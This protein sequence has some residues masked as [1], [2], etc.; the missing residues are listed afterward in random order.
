M[1][2]RLL[3]ELQPRRM[4]MTIDVVNDDGTITVSSG[5]G[6]TIR[7]LGTGSVGDKVYVQGGVVIGTAP[8]LTHYTIEV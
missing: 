4:I 7:V 6:G 1:Y 5:D 2:A 8:N 3:S